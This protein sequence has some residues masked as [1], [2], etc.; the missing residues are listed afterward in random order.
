MKIKIRMRREKKDKNEMT[1]VCA[2]KEDE[3]MQRKV[4]QEV[5]K[6]PKATRKKP[7]TARETR[8]PRKSISVR[9]ILIL[10]RIHNILT[11][12]RKTMIDKDKDEHADNADS[13]RR[14][15]TLNRRTIKRIS[16][17]VS[18][19]HLTLPTTPYV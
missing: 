13:H 16:K 8:I 2:M 14:A 6:M 9:G 5:E 1:V 15:N 18:Y 10:T 12:D 7:K 19:T 4:V 3:R 17:P 11:I